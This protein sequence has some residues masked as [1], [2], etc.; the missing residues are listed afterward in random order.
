VVEAG[1]RKRPLRGNSAAI[2][3]QPHTSGDELIERMNTVALNWRRL[4]AERLN[5]LRK[6]QANES[7]PAQVSAVSPS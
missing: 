4:M 2:T 1:A 3:S 7:K 6:I 5:V